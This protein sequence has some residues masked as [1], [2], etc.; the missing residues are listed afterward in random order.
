MIY[1][2]LKDYGDNIVSYM[3]FPWQLLSE[4]EKCKI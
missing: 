4:K 2:Y 3:P 1:T